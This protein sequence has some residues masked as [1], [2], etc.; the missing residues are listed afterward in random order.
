MKICIIT[1]VHNGLDA[2]IYS[3]EARA[4]ANAGHKILIISPSGSGDSINNITFKNY[5]PVKIKWLRLLTNFRYMTTGLQS[6]SDVFHFHDPD[7]ILFAILIKLISGKKV[8]FDVH[9][10]FS[11]VLMEATWLPVYVRQVFSSLYSFFEYQTSKVFDGIIAATDHI[12]S[13]F[14]KNRTIVIHNYPRTCINGGK[15][16]VKRIKN[17]IVFI[18]GLTR[19]RGIKEMLQAMEILRKKI[20]AEIHVYGI[21]TDPVFESEIRSLYNFDWVQFHGFVDNKD[22]YNR[23]KSCEVGILPYLPVP[24]HIEAM[25]TKLFE[26][27]MAGIPIACSNFPLWKDIVESHGIGMTFNPENLQEMADVLDNLLTDRNGLKK[28]AKAC[29]KVFSEKYNWES[30]EERFLNYYQSLY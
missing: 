20:N 19:I 14:D 3:R 6:R 1:T 28:K 5:K 21:F 17:S 9:E 18:G 2:R 26:Y 4:L 25:P 12:A 24:N 7:F 22:V 23:M 15:P 27:M 29:R 10:N 11:K 13:R 30:E 16:D 8:I